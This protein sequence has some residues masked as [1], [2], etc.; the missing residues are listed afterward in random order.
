VSANEQVSRENGSE[1]AVTLK[2]KPHGLRSLSNAR[3]QALGR[4]IP[5]RE[6]AE[7]LGVN[8]SN[9]SRILKGHADPGVPFIAGCLNV[10][11]PYSFDCIFDIVPDPKRGGA[12][13]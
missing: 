4:E 9:L 13:E 5:N 7:L 3:A 11:G 1:A 8:Q 6:L 10:F 12:A 2:L